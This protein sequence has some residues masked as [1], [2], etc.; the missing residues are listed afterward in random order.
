MLEFFLQ[1]MDKTTSG[2]TRSYTSNYVFVLP[3]GV[4]IVKREYDSLGIEDEHMMVW[5]KR[6]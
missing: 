4:A 6:K 3:M 5:V 2:Y 1:S